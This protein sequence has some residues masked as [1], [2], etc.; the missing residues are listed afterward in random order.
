MFRYF[1]LTALICSPSLSSIA[2]ADPLMTL[3]SGFDIKVNKAQI[4][5]FEISWHFDKNA[6]T[7]LLIAFD[8]NSDGQFKG[9][10]KLDL[11]QM[12]QQ[13]EDEDYLL[14]VQKNGIKLEP[15]SIQAIGIQVSDALVSVN[16]G[17][18]LKE[19]VDLQK[20][21]MQLA[22]V[23]NNRVGVDQNAIVPKIGGML[24]K[25]CDVKVLEKKALEG[26]NWHYIFCTK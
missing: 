11:I 23:D 15:E 3:G 2:S 13:F 17:V 14:Q 21:G 4:D 19:A 16:F 24:A 20:S 12:L 7:S 22:F 8:T 1:L 18:L 5:A 10:E 9:Q 25:N 26:H 6:S